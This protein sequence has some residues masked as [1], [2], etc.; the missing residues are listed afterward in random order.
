MEASDGGHAGSVQVYVGW[1]AACGSHGILGWHL[2]LSQLRKLGMT[3][4]VGPGLYRRRGEEGVGR[5]S[6]SL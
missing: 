5:N 6:S 2:A 3:A 4:C 1:L